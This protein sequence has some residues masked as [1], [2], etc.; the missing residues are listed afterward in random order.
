MFEKKNDNKV[1]V[2][3]PKEDENKYKIRH[4]EIK[5]INDWETAGVLDKASIFYI[6]YLIEKHFWNLN[7]KEIEDNPFENTG[8]EIK[9][10]GEDFSIQIKAQDWEKEKNGYL[11]FYLYGDLVVEFKWYKHC[12]RGLKVRYNNYD[13]EE[14]ISLLE[15]CIELYLVKMEEK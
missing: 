1:K 10:L 13:K 15:E 12:L 2:I 6:K 11:K 14:A 4:Y 8:G 9:A 3:A 5:G 7:Q